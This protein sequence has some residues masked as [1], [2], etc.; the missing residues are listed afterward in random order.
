M[1][2]K[3]EDL[4]SKLLSK[5]RRGSNEPDWNVGLST[6]STLLNLALSGRP[7]VG[8]VRGGI[9]YYVGDSGSGKSWF[10][11]TCMAEAAVNKHY[12]RYQF[13]YDNIENGALMDLRRFFG[14]RMAER[15]IPPK[16]TRDK[17]KYSDTLESLYYNVDD[18]LE[19]GPAIYVADSMD[20]LTSDDELDKFGENKQR[21]EKEQEAKGT[22]GMSKPKLNSTYLRVIHNKVRDTGS[23]LI[24]ISQTRDNVGPGAMFNPRTRAGGRA[25]TFY[26]QWEIWSSIKGH[27]LT[28][29]QGKDREQGVQCLLD[30]K[31]NRL[32]GRAG[33]AR[34]VVVPILHSVGIDDAGSLVDY[35]VEEGHWTSNK[36]KISAPEFD[37]TGSAD[38]L[39]QR[40]QDNNREDELRRLVSHVWTDIEDAI[41]AKRKPRYV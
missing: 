20:A 21:H 8:Y 18:V 22:F 24:L 10:T 39:I 1:P 37:F 28:T 4:K 19:R 7:H 26:S 12:D 34:K 30:I 32:T 25:L 35:L 31:K 29:Y 2:N 17:P 23:I 5:N 36:G 3:T 16:G 38:K 15:V 9:H 6:G 41:A 33:R 40:I 14:R 11:L 13:V 27:I